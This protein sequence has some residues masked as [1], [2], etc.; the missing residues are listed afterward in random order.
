MTFPI[1]RCVN[2]QRNGWLNSH[3]KN[4]SKTVVFAVSEVDEN[5]LVEGALYR[6][7]VVDGFE[8]VKHDEDRLIPHL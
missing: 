5:N 1:N 2:W 6:D 8:L 3:G 7:L 4:L